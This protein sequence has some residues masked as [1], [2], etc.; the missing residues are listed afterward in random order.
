[1]RIER[2]GVIGLALALAAVVPSCGSPTTQTS[3]GIKSSTTVASSLPPP[4]RATGSPTSLSPTASVRTE[5][6]TFFNWLHLW[7]LKD[8][9]APQ[10]LQD[11]MFHELENSSDT[12]LAA[13]A[14]S[15]QAAWNSPDVR[16]GLTYLSD[17]GK[18]CL[19]LGQVDPNGRAQ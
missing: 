16:T 3:H 1:M 19:A 5:C 10:E 18:R 4:S 14:H 9:T 2:I 8:H 17:V 6:L 12:E 13:S 11:L 15:W 7:H